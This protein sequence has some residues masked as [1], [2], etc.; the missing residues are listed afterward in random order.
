MGG[1]CSSR[2]FTVTSQDYSASS[3]DLRL[4]TP[5]SKSSSL[6]ILNYRLNKKKDSLNPY[7]M[8]S[9]F[10]EQSV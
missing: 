3:Q 7:Q 10:E 4:T 1:K 9:L 8:W 5:H 2:K 6:S